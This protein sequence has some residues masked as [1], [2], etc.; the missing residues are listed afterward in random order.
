MVTINS[1]QS[2][3]QEFGLKGLSTDT[4]PI[5]TFGGSKLLNGSTFYTM[6]TGDIYMY[7][8]ENQRWLLQ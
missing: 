2:A 6:D 4:K 1:S 5:D 3:S 8:A 7:D